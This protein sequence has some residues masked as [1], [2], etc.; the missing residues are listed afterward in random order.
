MVH[1]VGKERIEGRVPIRSI[2]Q[3]TRLTKGTRIGSLG[4]HYNLSLIFN[5]SSVCFV[6]IYMELLKRGS[7]FL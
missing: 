1:C 4:L 6:E 3:T 2:P 7:L 5:T